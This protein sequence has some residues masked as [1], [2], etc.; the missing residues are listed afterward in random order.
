MNGVIGKRFCPVVI[1]S[2]GVVDVVI[3]RIPDDLRIEV[4]VIEFGQQLLGR[5]RHNRH[6]QAN[7]TRGYSGG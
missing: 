5:R 4:S 3:N 2:Y 1:E 7:G 6:I